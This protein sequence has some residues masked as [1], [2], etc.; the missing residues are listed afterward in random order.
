MFHKSNEIGWFMRG[1][2]NEEWLFDI[3]VRLWRGGT[4][5]GI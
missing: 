2:V 4:M 5:S 3:D 1:R